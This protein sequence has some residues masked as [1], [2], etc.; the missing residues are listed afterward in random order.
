MNKEI[1]IGTKIKIML[2]SFLEL[3][4]DTQ[5]RFAPAQDAIWTVYEISPDF[6][7][8]F[9]RINDANSYSKLILK[10]HAII[11]DECPQQPS[12]S[13]EDTASTIKP[14]QEA[15]TATIQVTLT[16]DYIDS[17]Y[18]IIKGSK[19]TAAQWQHVSAKPIDMTFEHFKG[20][21]MNIKAMF[22]LIALG[23]LDD[24]PISTNQT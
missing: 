11:V 12:A 17:L 9:T 1:K 8:C 19:L 14:K 24:I 15:T 23:K 16:K 2:E 7:S 6:Y 4:A 5:Q 10:E 20:E 22:A 3:D 21:E 18:C 13:Q